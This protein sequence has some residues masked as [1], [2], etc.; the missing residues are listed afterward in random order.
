MDDDSPGHCRVRDGC[1]NGG[2]GGEYDKGGVYRWCGAGGC[3]DGNRGRSGIMDRGAVGGVFGLDLSA[4][5]R[6]GV[7]FSWK[8]L[9][10]S[11]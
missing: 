9:V 3:R 11:G 1:W 6:C 2:H 7:S 5:R 10:M 4:G 8:Y